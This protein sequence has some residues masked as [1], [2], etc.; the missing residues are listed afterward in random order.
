MLFVQYAIP[1]RELLAVATDPKQLPKPPASSGMVTLP[2]WEAVPPAPYAWDVKRLNFVLP[3]VSP[4]VS[5][6]AFMDRLGDDTVVAMQMAS[7]GDSMQ[8][9]Q[10]RTW[11]LR[12]QVVESVDVT[13]LRTVA[14]V[15]ALIAARLLPA[16]RRDA[17]LKVPDSRFV[18]ADQDTGTD[19]KGSG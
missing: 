11:L 4:N 5:R 9:A 18:A 19:P 1:S 8:A 15:D 3:D 10:L 12:Y 7:W 2:E 13:D 16:E 17:V 6:Q 14:G